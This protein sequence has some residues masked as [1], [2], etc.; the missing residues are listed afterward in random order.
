MRAVPLPS[1]QAQA[2]LERLALSRALLRQSLR[3]APPIGGAALDGAATDWAA[4]LKALPVDGLLLELLRNW[5]QQQ[6]IHATGLLLAD[7]SKEWLQAQALRHPLRLAAAA[8]LLGGLLV[9]SRPWRWGLVKPALLTGMLPQM[10]S[11][12]IGSASLL[13][14][15]ASLAAQAQP[16]PQPP[17]E[18][19]SPAQP[20][21]S[22]NRP[23]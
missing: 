6:P 8:A 15:L 13:S 18:P 14:W 16:Q 4:L 7:V 11:K 17:A 2:A 10:L 12:I 9:W 21:A 23:Q 20:P 1:P 22:A 3:Q 5:W 19:Q